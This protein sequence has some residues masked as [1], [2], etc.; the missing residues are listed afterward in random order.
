MVPQKLC[1]LYLFKNPTILL[2]APADKGKVGLEYVFTFSMRS[3][4]AF[5]MM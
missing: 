3:S 5:F 1:I 2:T 4:G